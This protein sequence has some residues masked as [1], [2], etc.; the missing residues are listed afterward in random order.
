MW[1]YVGA[2]RTY[3]G[4]CGER[5]QPGGPRYCSA[6]CRILGRRHLREQQDLP[7]ELT[8]GRCPW[9][10]EP[11]WGRSYDER[12]ECWHDHL[13]VRCGRRPSY[14]VAAWMD[15]FRTTANQPFVSAG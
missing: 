3:C 8:M 5:I 9:C 2:S 13:A 4:Y 12:V 11:L 15:R 14:E 7:T 1:F 6:E 10:G